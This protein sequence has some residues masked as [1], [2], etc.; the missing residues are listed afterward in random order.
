MFSPAYPGEAKNLLWSKPGLCAPNGIAMAAVAVDS[1]ADKPAKRICA[2]PLNNRPAFFLKKGLVISVGR[3]YLCIRFER[4]AAMKNRLE[5]KLRKKFCRFK[6]S[7][8]L[9]IRFPKGWQN[10]SRSQLRRELR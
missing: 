3:M 1:L 9:C 2:N 10:K 8:Y 5:K 7:I 4:E 6:K